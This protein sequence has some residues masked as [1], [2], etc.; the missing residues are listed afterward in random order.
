[1]PS[2]R[3]YRAVTRVYPP[4]FRR[5]YGEPMVQLFA[6]RVRRDGGRRAWGSALR[7]VSISAPYQY[8]ESLMN[9]SP[10]T[11]LTVAAVL[12]GIAAIAFLL[13][14]GAILGL[15]LL[16]VLAWE[17]YAILRMRGHRVSEQRWW[18][19]AGSGV[20]LFAVLFIIFA[21]PWPEDWRSAV[22]GELAWTVA[23]FGF[24]ASIV[25]VVLG[26]FMGVAQ[27]ASRRGT[28]GGATA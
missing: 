14:G 2:V 6:D 24:S 4:K 3:T 13:V 28:S 15:V 8:W 27:L 11:K 9:A 7:D 10:Q 1:M 21:M 12:T 16:L 26:L 18:K 25:L 20:A 19:F 17:L 22:P 5:E 23:M